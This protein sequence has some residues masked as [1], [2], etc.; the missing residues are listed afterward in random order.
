MKMK[1]LNS[2]NT[3]VFVSCTI[4]EFDAP[5]LNLITVDNDLWSKNLT[6]TVGKKNFEDSP[7]IL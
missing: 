4:N 1:S 3:S 5:H 7:G 2:I 6:F